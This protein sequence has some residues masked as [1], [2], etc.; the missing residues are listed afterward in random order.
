MKNKEL[1][2]YLKQFPDD[3]QINIGTM[4]H[5]RRKLF[6]YKTKGMVLVKDLDAPLILLEICDRVPMPKEGVKLFKKGR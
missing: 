6:T 4:K 1:I 2:D 5:A 3:A